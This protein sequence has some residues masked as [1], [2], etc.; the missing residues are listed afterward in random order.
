MN[1]AMNCYDSSPVFMSF[2][3]LTVKPY[4]VMKNV[5]CS[6]NI[7]MLDVSLFLIPMLK[8]NQALMMQLNHSRLCALRILFV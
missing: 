6:T 2:Y 8:C 3:L 7:Y 1:T 5:S 4:L